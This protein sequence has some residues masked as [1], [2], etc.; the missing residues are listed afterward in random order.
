MYNSNPLSSFRHDSYVPEFD[1]MPL[2]NAFNIDNMKEKLS[3]SN[4]TDTAKFASIN[5]QYSLNNLNVANNEEY[6]KRLEKLEN[7][8]SN[9]DMDDVELFHNNNASHYDTNYIN[10]LISNKKQQQQSYAQLYDKYMY[11]F[12]II[13]LFIITLFQKNRIQNLQDMLMYPR[14]GILDVKSTSGLV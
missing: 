3:N 7:M 2:Y 5:G 14:N 1:S 11:I 6:I 12:L 13:I 4:N 8:T 10:Y 9:N